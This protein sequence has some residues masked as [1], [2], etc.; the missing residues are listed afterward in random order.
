MGSLIDSGIFI[1]AER[2]RIDLDAMVAEFSDEPV[3]ISVVTAGELLHDV[4][5]A[6]EPARRAA[7]SEAVERVLRRFHVIPFD[8]P[9]ARLYA[10][11]VAQRAAAGRPMASHDLMIAAAALAR[12]YRVITR[13]AKSF[14]QITGLE[15]VLR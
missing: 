13:D 12:G 5:R 3:M 4:H 10:E 7:R 2:K 14:P 8:L 11:L 6:N 15:V 9:I 1:A